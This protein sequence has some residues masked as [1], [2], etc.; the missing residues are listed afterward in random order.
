MPINLD[1]PRS[2]IGWNAYEVIQWFMQMSPGQD[3]GTSEMSELIKYKDAVDEWN[4]SGYKPSATR[5]N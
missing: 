1:Q 3:E 2:T 4:G 5:Q